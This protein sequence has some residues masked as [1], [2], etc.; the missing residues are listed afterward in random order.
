MEYRDYYKILGVPRDAPE[1]EIK[2]AYRRLARQYHPDR[3]PGDKAAEERFKEINEAH[4]VLTDPGKRS[5]YDRLGAQWQNW[6]R[7]GGNAGDFDF[8]QWFTGRPGGTQMDYGDLDDLLGQAGP[9]SDF[10]QS[11]FGQM[12]PQPRGRRQR[13]PPRG[14]RGQDYEQPVDITLEEAYQGTSRVLDVEGRRLE[15]KIPPGVKT[16]SKVRMAGK[17][18]AG[19]GSGPPG[20]VF[21]RIKVVPHKVF[22]RKGD[23]LNCEVP[24]ELYTALLGGEVRVPTL[25]GAVRLKIPP[26]T[27]AGSSF[28]LRGKGMPSLRD[29]QRFGDLYA[30]V[31]VNLPRKL[32]EKEKE[33]IRKLA[34]LRDGDGSAR[35]Q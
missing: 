8:S 19:L 32:S 14:R 3:N 11:I 23:D 7:M 12:G 15:V 30:K 17:G 10:F 26:E 4:E 27:Q 21:L 31:R 2:R 1:R 16:G 5:K 6:Q 13:T 34:G 22:K 33:L 29:P 25:G 20:D 24:V 35:G 18:G 28:R 9:F